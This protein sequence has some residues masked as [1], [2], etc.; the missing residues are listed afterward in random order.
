MHPQL[1]S[2]QDHLNRLRRIE[3]QVR[4]LQGMVDTDK[5]CLDT[6]TQIAATTSALKSF[7]LALLSEHVAGCVLA[8]ATT[9]E[10]E[11]GNK[12]HEATGAVARLLRF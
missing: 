3:G 9:N 6:L 1:D 5:P 7:S 2:K 4:G 8:A 12:I 11:A 10:V